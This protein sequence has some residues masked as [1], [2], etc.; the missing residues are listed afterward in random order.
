MYWQDPWYGV[1]NGHE[2]TQTAWLGDSQL[3]LR[4]FPDSPAAGFGIAPRAE[5]CNIGEGEDPISMFLVV[6]FKE[7][8]SLVL[9]WPQ[10]FFSRIR[11]I[12][13]IHIEIAWERIEW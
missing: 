5:S 9:D 4:F 3:V 12:F 2:I 10:P 1:M 13:K 6:K 8:D 7:D 11:Y